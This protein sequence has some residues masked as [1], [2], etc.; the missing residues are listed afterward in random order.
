MFGVNFY[1]NPNNIRFFDRTDVGENCVYGKRSN[2]FKLKL[3]ITS[4]RASVNRCLFIYFIF[5]FV[6][7]SKRYFQLRLSCS[8]VHCVHFSCSI[9]SYVGRITR[10][11]IIPTPSRACVRIFILKRYFFFFFINL[12]FSRHLRLRR[13]ART[14]PM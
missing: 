1:H 8:M 10:I 3:S 11:I 6:K 13:N 4:I 9:T 12:F 7:L 2:G 5:I 14:L